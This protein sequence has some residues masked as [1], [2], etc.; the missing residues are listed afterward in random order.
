MAEQ[1]IIIRQTENYKIQQDSNNNTRIIDIKADCVTSWYVNTR[2]QEQI[3][4]V[5]QLRGDADFDEYC[6][7]EFCDRRG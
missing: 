7:R 1:V 2:A 3:N 5:K 4:H 6:R